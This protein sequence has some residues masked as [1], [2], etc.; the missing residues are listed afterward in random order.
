MLLDAGKV[1]FVFYRDEQG[2]LMQV[3]HCSLIYGLSKCA[4]ANTIH[5]TQTVS[6]SVQL[7]PP[8]GA[9]VRGNE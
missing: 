1:V 7:V 4:G 2:R 6:E 3:G 9:I 8:L 5:K